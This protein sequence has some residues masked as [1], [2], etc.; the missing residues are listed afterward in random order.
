MKIK[1]GYVKYQLDWESGPGASFKETKRLISW[2]DTIMSNGDIG[3]DLELKVGV[4]NISERGSDGAFLIS[5]TGTG[6][7]FPSRSNVFTRVVAC[8]IKRNR[9][10]CI[11]PQKAS[12]ES[13]THYAC[14]KGNKSV[15]AV[16]HI[17][18]KRLWGIHCGVSPSTEVGIE[19]GTP[20]MALR[21]SELAASGATVI[22][23]KGHTDGLLVLGNDLTEAG[24]T[25][26]KL[27][28]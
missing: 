10:S 28:K 21:V 3:Y 22:A 11:G 17:H 2:R 16:I 9:V 12:S 18:N 14:Y 6:A 1:E 15:G 4:G 24:S 8:D 13:M 7:I 25:Y 23:M 26:L 20:E 19:Y 27:R 5:G